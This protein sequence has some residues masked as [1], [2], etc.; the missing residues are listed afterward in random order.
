STDGTAF[1][2]GDFF[3]LRPTR[4]D[5]A[6]F[7]PTDEATR[8]CLADPSGDRSAT[9]RLRA[10]EIAVMSAGPDRRL[11]LSRRVAASGPNGG[12]NVNEDNLVETGP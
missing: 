10:A 4:A 12:V 8:E 11:D 9:R 3:A 7:V 2:L 1:D 6:D 5:E